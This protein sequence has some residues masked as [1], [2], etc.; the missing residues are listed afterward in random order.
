MFHKRLLKEFTENRKYVVGMVAAQW[1]TLL[2][3]VVL[4]FVLAQFVSNL[5]ENRP[6]GN[7]IIF[8]PVTLLAVMLVRAAANAIQ[9]KFSFLASFQVKKRLREMTYEKLMRFGT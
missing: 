7:L 4:V 8:L 1:I 9:Q 3:N 6:Q 2:A 5:L